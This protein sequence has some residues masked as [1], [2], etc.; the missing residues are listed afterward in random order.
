MILY[1]VQKYFPTDFTKKFIECNIC[2][3]DN[4]EREYTFKEL[5]SIIANEGTILMGYKKSD[6]EYNKDRNYGIYLNPEK[7]NKIKLSK[8]D[9]VI[10]LFEG[11]S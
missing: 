9:K 4:F 7:N 3:I 11:A 8:D 2:S 10:I 6:E 1:K 5:T